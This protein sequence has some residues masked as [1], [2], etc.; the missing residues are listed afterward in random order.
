VSQV[1]YLQELPLL[2]Y[3]YFGPTVT[4]EAFF[5]KKSGLL[6]KFAY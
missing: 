6:I 4:T 5:L 2:V 3:N 1:G